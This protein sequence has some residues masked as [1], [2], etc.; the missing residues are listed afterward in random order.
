GWIEVGTNQPNRSALAVRHGFALN[1]WHVVHLERPLSAPLAEPRSPAGFTLRPLAGPAEVEAYVALH[2]AAFGTENM[3]REWR[4][5]TLE[6]P[7][8]ASALDLVAVAPGGR[9]A[10]FCICWPSHAG[11]RSV[12]QIEPLGVHP[13][14]Q[15]L[16][17]GHV[18]LAEALG[19]M[20]EHAAEWALVETYT[21][22]PDALRLY[23]SAGFRAT[24]TIARYS[25]DV[26]LPGERASPRA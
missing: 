5:R 16:G 26:P 24:A 22:L 23:T 2:R 17:L 14:F 18:L 15:R 6:M 7:Q 13:D 9:L 12:C 11:G 3:T 4:R 1:D 25:R 8:H 20:R 19:R 10:G 21:V